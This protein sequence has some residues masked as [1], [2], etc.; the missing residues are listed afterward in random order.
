LV[1]GRRSFGKW[2]VQSI[3]P[4]ARSSGLRLTT[5][6]FYS[7]AGHN[8]SKV[9]VQPDITVAAPKNKDGVYRRPTRHTLD[10]DADVRKAL[11][12]LRARLAG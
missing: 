3:F 11:E 5:A 12:E 10:D 4:L 2:S 1:I 6:K 8:L 7:P 9:G